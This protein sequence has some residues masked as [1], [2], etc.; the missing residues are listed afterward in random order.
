M[1]NNDGPVQFFFLYIDGANFKTNI[2]IIHAT[3]TNIPDNC[4]IARI[5][6]V[7]LQQETKQI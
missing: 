1:N 4:P 2:P 5:F 7:S 6:K 3:R